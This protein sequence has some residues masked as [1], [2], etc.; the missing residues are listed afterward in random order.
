MAVQG[1][2]FIRFMLD[3]NEETSPLLKFDIFNLDEEIQNELR[4][5]IKKEGKLV[6]KA[7]V[8]F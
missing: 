6:Y 4:E 7:N 1:D 2:D 8:S 3:I 5:A